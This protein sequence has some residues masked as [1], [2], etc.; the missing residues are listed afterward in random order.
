MS[1]TKHTPGPWS[2]KIAV[3]IT[4][5]MLHDADDM[6]DCED[7]QTMFFWDAWPISPIRS[8]RIWA[9]FTQPINR[10]KAQTILA[11]IP[12]INP[13]PAMTH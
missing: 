3:L 5:E 7:G 2:A 9:L 10:Q 13:N 4:S 8:I 12:C 1:E 6:P 11:R